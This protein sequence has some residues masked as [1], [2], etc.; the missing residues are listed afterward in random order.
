MNPVR[1]KWKL[2]VFAHE[3]KY[4]SAGYYFD[5]IDEFGLFENMDPAY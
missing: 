5:N 3:Y 2:S 1:E 4:S